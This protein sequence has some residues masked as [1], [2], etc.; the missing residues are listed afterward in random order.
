[1]RTIMVCIM[2]FGLLCPATPAGAEERGTIQLTV[3]AATERAGL[4]LPVA[5]ADQARIASA[6]N[7]VESFQVVVRAKGEAPSN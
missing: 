7:E 4:D 5:G 3:L 1:M 2:S 6:R